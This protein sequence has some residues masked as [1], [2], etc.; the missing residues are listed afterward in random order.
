MPVQALNQAL[1]LDLGSFAANVALHG[2][3]AGDV[4]EPFA[5]VLYEKINL[6]NELVA[7]VEF[8]VCLSAGG[9][10]CGV[11]QLSLSSGIRPTSG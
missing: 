10:R 11:L 3:G 7:D 8:K 2:E 6:Q 4:V 5:D 9:I 1:T